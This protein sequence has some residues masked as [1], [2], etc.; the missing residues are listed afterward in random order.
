[1]LAKNGSVPEHVV[2]WRKRTPSKCEL[3]RPIGTI[4]VPI[5]KSKLTWRYPGADGLGIFRCQVSSFRDVSMAAGRSFSGWIRKLSSADQTKILEGHFRGSSEACRRK[6]VGNYGVEPEV[7]IAL[8]DCT[9]LFPESGSWRPSG[10]RVPP[11]VK[12]FQPPV[13]FPSC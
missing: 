6:I 8:S 4:S 2:S 5:S 10:R 11:K 9:T 12:K 1:M 13:F 3:T 7:R